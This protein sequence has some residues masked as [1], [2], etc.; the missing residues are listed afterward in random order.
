VEGTI[1]MSMEVNF[2]VVTYRWSLF[3]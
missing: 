3:I 2:V 1:T